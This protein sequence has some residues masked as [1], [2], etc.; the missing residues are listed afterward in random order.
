MGVPLHFEMLDNNNENSNWEDRIKLFSKVIKTLGYHR[1]DY[2][3]MDREFI[4]YKWLRWLK[5]LKIDFCVRVPKHHKILSPEG[6]RFSAEDVLKLGN[7]K[8]YLLPNHVVDTVSLNVSISYDD[9]ELLYLVGTIASNKLKKAYKKRWS[10]EVFF[11]ALK[12]RGF[13]MEKSCIRKLDRYKKL[14]AVV[15]MSYTI[16]WGM[17]IYISK[18]NPVGL[19]KHGYPQFSVFRRGLNKVREMI[20]SIDF[21]DFTNMISHFRMNYLKI[22]G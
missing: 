19:K 17:G 18:K 22:I 7:R 15:S 4:G 11:Q 2:I 5:S 3:V 20:K 9:D 14:F 10:I 8:V 21:K 16:C 12:G 6:D 13:N 1:I